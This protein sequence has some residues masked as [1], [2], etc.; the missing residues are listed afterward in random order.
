MQKLC[1]N[2]FMTE[3]KVLSGKFGAVDLM[4]TCTSGMQ[5][6]VLVDGRHHFV[7][8]RKERCAEEQSDA[9]ARFNTAALSAGFSVIRLHYKDIWEVEYLLR[10]YLSKINSLKRPTIMLSPSFFNT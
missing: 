10:T 8:G 5:V 3:V 1:G 7:G 2:N 6:V 9:D 4:V